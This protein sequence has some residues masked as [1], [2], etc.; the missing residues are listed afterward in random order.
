[1]SCL[2]PGKILIGCKFQHK[3]EAIKL[4][5][6][7]NHGKFLK[8]IICEGKTSKHD[9]RQIIQNKETQR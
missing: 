3:H 5:K 1:M 4:F 2:I 9:K 8:S 7:R 6:E